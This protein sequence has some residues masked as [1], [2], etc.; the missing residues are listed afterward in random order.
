MWFLTGLKW[1]KKLEQWVCCATI[2]KMF[3]ICTTQ[4]HTYIDTYSIAY[5]ARIA[6]TIQTRYHVSSVRQL[7]EQAGFLVSRSLTL[8]STPLEWQTLFDN[9]NSHPKKKSC[10]AT[11]HL[12]DRV[13]YIVCLERRWLPFE[14]AS[15]RSWVCSI[16]YRNQRNYIMSIL[17]W[18]DWSI[19]SRG[20]PF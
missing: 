4:F 6:G 16:Q 9:F 20:S 12:F 8:L 14:L 18:F 15:N 19:P 13:Y 11:A 7:K 5:S 1:K 2:S 3:L 10:M 17:I